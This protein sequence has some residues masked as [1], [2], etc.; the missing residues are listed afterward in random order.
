MKTKSI[1]QKLWF[2]LI[3]F[4]LVGFATG[5]SQLTN[6]P[7]FSDEPTTDKAAFEVLSEEDSSVY[8]FYSNYNEEDAMEFVL[9]VSSST[10]F[11]KRVGHRVR[12]V[13]RNMET[14]IVGDTAYATLTLTFEGKLFIAASFD[15]VS[16]QVDTIIQ[17][18]FSSQIKRNLIFIRIGASPRPRLNWRLAATSLPIGGT[19][20]TGTFTSNIKIEKLTLTLPNNQVIE[21]NSALDY[22][23]WF[24]AGGNRLPI[25]SVAKGQEINIK[26]E[27]YSAYGTID[28]VTVTY[29]A[30]RFGNHR[31]K[32]KLNLVSSVQSGNGFLK[33]YETNLNVNQIA[34][35]FHAVLNAMPH[36]VIFDG[37][38]AVET[39]SWGMPYHVRR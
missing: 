17:K 38:A 19:L 24:G 22:Y 5:C 7:D 29:G 39:S 18:E 31:R 15:S 33:V 20:E 26:A 35:H 34:G 3:G 32:V 28:F 13:S 8:S 14:N 21:I 25:P 9:G 2:P 11:P 4:I 37:N 1:I 23:F 27:V 16:T 36:Q 30:D 6:E 10:Y 12:L